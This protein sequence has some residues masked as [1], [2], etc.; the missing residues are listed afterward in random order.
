[1][2][3]AAH[4]GEAV[5][6]RARVAE[7][8]R[9]GGPEVL[10][11]VERE[12]PPPGAGELRVAVRAAGLNRAE[13]LFVAGRY[14]VQP[15]SLPSRVGIEAVGTVEALGA[16]VAGLELGQSV[17]ILPSLDPA[18]H[19]VIGELAVVPA[20]AVQR[21]PAG[22]EPVEAAALW[23]AYGTA[24]GGLVNAGGLRAGDG[25]TVLVS[26]ASSSVGLAAIAV[27]KAHG[28]TVIAT[29]RTGAKREA[30]VAAGADRVLATDGGDLVERVAEATDGAGVDLAF[31]PVNGAFVET[32]AR[33]AARDGRIVEYGLL[34]GEVAPLPFGE[35]I[36]K[37][38]SIRT[39]HLGFDLLGRPDR[40]D[41]A[42]AALTPRF[43]DG[44]YRATI[45]RRYPL[46]RVADA[47]ARLAGNEQVGKIVVE[48]SA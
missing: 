40:A 31:D 44:T 26:A 12:I 46:E 43:E 47:C 2:T 42:M 10:R 27:A 8:D 4:R 23:M 17:S 1:M 20:A 36:G 14:L 19:G 39:F 45:D 15:A 6:R 21:A 34:A 33:C 5:A 30:L 38:L 37:G 25:S 41:E 24:W 9:L 11:V 3:G 13:L 29:T 32:L 48:V 28:A 22:V 7:F 16:G 35:M 18:R